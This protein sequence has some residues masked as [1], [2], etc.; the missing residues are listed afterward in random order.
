[1]KK[2]KITA[3]Q[4]K[5]MTYTQKRIDRFKKIK[6]RLEKTIDAHIQI[7]M[8]MTSII[9]MYFCKKAKI[10]NFTYVLNRLG[11][12]DKLFILKDSKLIDNEL[13]KELNKINT[14][15]NRTVHIYYFPSISEAR[16][17]KTTFSKREFEEKTIKCILKLSDVHQKILHKK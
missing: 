9:A 8:L 17:I 10:L 13:F 1:M 7:D 11:F 4:K 12:M 15:R 3:R 5:I 6:N 14:I 16:K 2:R